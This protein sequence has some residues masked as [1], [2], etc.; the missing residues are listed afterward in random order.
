MILLGLVGAVVG[1]PLGFI[2]GAALAGVLVCRGGNGGSASGESCGM[3]MLIFSGLGIPIGA[4]VGAI[5]GVV[6]G[7]R[8]PQAEA[9]TI[10]HRE[11]TVASWLAVAGGLAIAS[12]A[13]RGWR[14]VS[15]PYAE[16]DR[17]RGVLTV[18]PEVLGFVGG[19]I[20]LAGGVL[21]VLRPAAPAPTVLIGVGSAVSLACV[22]WGFADLLDVP[23]E[24]ARQVFIGYWITRAGT[25]LAMIGWLV[26]R[27]SGAATSAT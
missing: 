25:G 4:L 21:R 14:T 24:L 7:R 27:R 10:I 3:S 19:L 2:S 1:V 12:G 23:A 26:D 8:D 20:V 17:Y 11:A 16:L 18:G 6:V 9:G 13:F 5:F 15:I 22:I